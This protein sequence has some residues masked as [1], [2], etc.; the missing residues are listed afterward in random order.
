M[1]GWDEES[2]LVHCQCVL[3]L[4]NSKPMAVRPDH[5]LLR[6]TRLVPGDEEEWALVVFGAVW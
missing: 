6:A 2:S 4:R 1:A 3:Q 5:V